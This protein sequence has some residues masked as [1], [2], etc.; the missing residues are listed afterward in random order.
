M[1]EVDATL[2][3]DGSFPNGCRLI[4]ELKA[5]GNAIGSLELNTEST[6]MLSQGGALP[7][8]PVLPPSVTRINEVTAAINTFGCT[9]ESRIDSVE[10]QV[11]GIG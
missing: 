11:L 1:T 3:F 4:M 5:N 7:V 6:Q 2:A 9:P 8:A 10:L